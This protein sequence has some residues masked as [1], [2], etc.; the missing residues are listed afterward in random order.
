MN[1][2]V[3][4]TPATGKT[5]VA[6]RLADELSLEWL[7][8]NEECLNN[9][10]FLGYDYQRDAYII[11]EELTVEFLEKQ[12]T[13]SSGLVLSGPI[14]PFSIDF[15]KLIVVLH[16]SPQDLRQRMAA[17]GYGERKIQENI[18]AELLSVVLGDV[19]DLFPYTNIL[20]FDTTKEDLDVMVKEIVD[21]LTGK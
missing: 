21:C 2:F 8:I 19:M 17:R 20:E 18:D 13:K 16:A 3:T 1:V 14:L 10:L 5:V 4:G 6:S 9:S 7:E 11:D 12:A 15:F